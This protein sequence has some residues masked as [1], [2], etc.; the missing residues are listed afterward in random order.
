MLTVSD[1][2]LTRAGRVIQA[3]LS[4]EIGAGRALSLRGPN[5]VG[6]S[7]LLRALAGL[8]RP[9]RGQILLDGATPADR[10]RWSELV[11]YA[12]HTDATKAQLSVRENLGFWAGLFG[13]DLDRAIEALDLGPIADRLAGTCSAGQKRRLGLARLAVSPA[14]LWLLDEPT[15]ALD[16]A[17]RSAFAALLRDHLGAGNQAVIATHDPDLVPGLQTLELVPA[18]DTAEEDPFLAGAF[19]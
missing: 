11:A 14:Q 19:G 12:G 17:A 16:Q 9:T 7:T 5:G 15:T 1:L 2:V 10:D 3:G 4:F 18:E 8:L 6:K 13:G